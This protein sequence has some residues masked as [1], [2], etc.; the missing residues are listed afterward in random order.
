MPGRRNAER[1]DVSALPDGFV[2][3]ANVADVPAGGMKCVAIDRER[4]LLAHVEGHFY[5][6]HDVCGHR[7]APLS[8][9]LLDGYNVECPLHYAV[10]D[11]R[12]GRLREGP[13]SANVP[14][15]ET[16]VEGDTVFVKR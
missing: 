15:Y 8:R 3:V 5:A 16:R 14:V 12:N 9:G 1:S 2:A 4:V 10:F 6:L 11:V 13:V 7:N